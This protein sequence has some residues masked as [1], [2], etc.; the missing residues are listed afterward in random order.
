MV[1]A[2][3]ARN[4]GA[5]RALRVRRVGASN[6]VEA[7]GAGSQVATRVHEARMASVLNIVKARNARALAIVLSAQHAVMSKSRSLNVLEFDNA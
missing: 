3:G 7:S 2:S 4:Q 1:E 5:T 6:T